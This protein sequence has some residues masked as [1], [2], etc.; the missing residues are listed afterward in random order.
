M[1]GLKALW[2]QAQLK[3]T[4]SFE[5]AMIQNTFPHQK[6]RGH[7]PHRLKEQE[8]LALHFGAFSVFRGV[9]CCAL[10]GAQAGSPSLD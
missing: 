6:V 9:L 7:S 1:Q 2:E 3:G 5:T 10:E 8:G 4:H